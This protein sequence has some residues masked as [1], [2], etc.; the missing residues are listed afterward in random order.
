[1]FSMHHSWKSGFVFTLHLPL[2]VFFS[3]YLKV[4]LL[5]MFFISYFKK[6]DSLKFHFHLLLLLLIFH[7]WSLPISSSTSPDHLAVFSASFFLAS[8]SSAIP[9]QKNPP[10]YWDKELAEVQKPSS[11]LNI[12]AL[13]L[14]NTVG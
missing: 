14:W 8:S 4:I 2:V 9:P 5:S 6:Q 13:M 7:N 3:A 12:A 11:D 1:M 10:A